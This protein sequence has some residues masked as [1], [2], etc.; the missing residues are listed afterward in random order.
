MGQ[1]AVTLNG[2]T[3][4]LKCG[5]G[6]EQRLHRL[7]EHVREKVDNLASDYGEIGNERLLLMTSIIIADEL[8]DDQRDSDQGVV[9]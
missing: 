3:Y 4:R 9:A 1:V 2:H 6:E 7:V 5:D 8:F